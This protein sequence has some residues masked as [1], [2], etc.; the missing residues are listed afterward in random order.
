MSVVARPK[1]VYSG[2]FVLPQGNIELHAS[3]TLSIVTHVLPQGYSLLYCGLV[4][5]FC[6]RGAC[7]SQNTSQVRAP[8]YHEETYFTHY[9]APLNRH[10]TDS[11]HLLMKQK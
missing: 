3:Y 9:S 4:Y 10:D 8:G 5:L 1:Q 11:R 2:V 6:I 7:H